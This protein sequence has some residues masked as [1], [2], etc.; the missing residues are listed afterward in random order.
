MLTCIDKLVLQHSQ[1]RARPEVPI[2]DVQSVVKWLENK[3]TAIAAAEVEYLNHNP[4]I[5]Y[6]DADQPPF[7]YSIVT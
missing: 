4:Q 5:F 2:E 7:L 6:L 3:E 1:L